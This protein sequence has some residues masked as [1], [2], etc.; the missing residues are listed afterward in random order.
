MADP[1]EGDSKYMAPELLSGGYNTSADMFSIGVTILEVAGDLD[2]P[3][4]GADWRFLRTGAFPEKQLI[5]KG[6]SFDF[7]NNIE[8]Y[9]CGGQTSLLFTIMINECFLSTVSLHTVL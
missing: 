7:C 4:G 3:N 5:E 9:Y 6:T 2:L 8:Q 1:C